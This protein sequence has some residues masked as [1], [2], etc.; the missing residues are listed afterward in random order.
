MNTMCMRA[1]EGRYHLALYDGER[2]LL[3][4]SVPLIH[5]TLKPQNNMQSG[6]YYF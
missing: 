4:M 3:H 1:N 5:P 2:E 6:G